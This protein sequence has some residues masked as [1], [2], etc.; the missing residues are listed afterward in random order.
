M[1]RR[2]DWVRR[3]GAEEGESL[4]TQSYDMKFVAIRNKKESI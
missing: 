2:R 4:H 3:G 1:E